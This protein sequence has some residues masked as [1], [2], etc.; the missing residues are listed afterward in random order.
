MEA[1]LREIKQTKPLKFDTVYFGGGTPSLIDG[2]NLKRIVECISTYHE[3][4]KDA[5]ITIEANPMT[6]SDT[7]K[8]YDLKNAGFNRLSLGVQ[9]FSDTELEALGRGHTADEAIGT[10][11]VAKDAGF[12]NI[13]IDLMFAIPHQSVKS[14]EDTLDTAISLDVSH[15]SVYAL[16]IEEKTVFGVKQ[17]RGENLFLPSE[18]EE[19]E[20]YFLACNKLEAAGYK[21][22]EISNFAKDNKRSRH[23]MKYWRGEEY[24]GIGASA[25][26]YFENVRYSCPADVK[27]FLTEATKE[28]CY[29]NEISDRAEETVFLSLRLRD[30]LDFEFLEKNYPV[31]RKDKFDEVINGLV[32]EGFCLYD[33]KTLSLTDKGFFVSNAIIIKIL[34]S[35]QFTS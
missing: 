6:L 34:D 27:A 19:T 33:G 12:D 30:G 31:K 32:S 23:N 29:T 28:D 15:I 26:S 5:E 16:S 8:L 35:L 7:K 13:S 11:K 9:S 4:T 20:M 18:D 22:Y 14:F 17:K 21:H 25:H 3:V 2:V 10:V 1:L 24:V